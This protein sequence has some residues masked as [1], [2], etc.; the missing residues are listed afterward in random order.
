CSLRFL[1]EM[2]HCRDK[3]LD[4]QIKKIR[5]YL[6]RGRRLDICAMARRFLSGKARASEG[7][8]IRQL[9]TDVDRDQRHLLRLAE[10]RELPQMGTRG[11]RWLCV[12]AQGP[13]LHHQPPR[14]GG[15]R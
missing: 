15:G 8:P 2:R 11:A 6:Y 9:E 10:A 7:A 13:A 14:A 1:F 3:G 4:S 12:L 5:P